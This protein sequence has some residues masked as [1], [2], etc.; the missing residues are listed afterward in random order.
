MIEV[1]LDKKVPVGARF[2]ILGTLTRPPLAW[3]PQDDKSRIA[4]ER[5]AAVLLPMALEVSRV[6]LT[7]AP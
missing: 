7:A 4:A 1:S 5:Y 3:R 6:P 2:S